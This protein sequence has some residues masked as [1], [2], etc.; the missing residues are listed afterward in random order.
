MK[1]DNLSLNEP[2][3]RIPPTSMT[4]GFIF[5]ITTPNIQVTNT[6]SACIDHLT[7]LI[8]RPEHME[9]IIFKALFNYCAM[10]IL[11]AYQLNR[12]AIV[13]L[14]LHIILFFLLAYRL[15]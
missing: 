3:C 2:V 8:P 13:H 4:Q 6:L 15:S 14:H 1:P 11:S 5:C 10:R 12:L 7:S 9:N